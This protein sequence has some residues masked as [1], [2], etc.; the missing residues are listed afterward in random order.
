[1]VDIDDMML[2]IGNLDISVVADLGLISR[3]C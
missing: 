2:T 1:M 3:Y